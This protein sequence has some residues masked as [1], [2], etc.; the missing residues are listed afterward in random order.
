MIMI[1]YITRI[2]LPKSS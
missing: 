2:K 1:I